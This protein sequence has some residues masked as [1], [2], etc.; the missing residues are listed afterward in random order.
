M[1]LFNGNTISGVKLFI[2]TKKTWINKRK[3][4][5]QFAKMIFYGRARCY[6]TEARI[7]AHGSLGTLCSRILDSLSFIKNYCLPADG[8]K[9]FHF[10]L[11]QGITGHENIPVTKRVHHGLSVHPG[12]GVQFQGRR[13]PG[14]LCFP[15]HTDRCRGN[16][17]GRPILGPV[18][19]NSQRLQR[20]SKSHIIGKAPSHP[21]MRKPGHPD[22]TFCL[23]VTQLSLQS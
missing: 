12:Q 17:K 1:M 8:F 9:E 3:E 10:L 18:E 16:N 20:F 21:D 5:P 14:S 6:Q 13:K 7:Q 4:I 22:K 11:E 2:G 23:I 15:V 19:N